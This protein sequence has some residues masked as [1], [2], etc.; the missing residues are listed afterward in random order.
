MALISCPEC[1]KK[2]SEHAE[3]CPECG[4]PIAAAKESKGSGTILVTQQ[5]TSKKLKLHYVLATIAMIVGV[6]W[7]FSIP[8]GDLSSARHT[9]VLVI[10]FGFI[11]YLVTRVRVWWH[12]K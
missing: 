1:G 5:E 2:V 9:S 3:S 4:N 7:F 6:V 12:H 11:W 10:V 8:E